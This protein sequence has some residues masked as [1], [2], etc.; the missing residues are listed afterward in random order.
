M[1]TLLRDFCFYCIGSIMRK[2]LTIFLLNVMALVA[3]QPVLAMHYCGGK[4]YSWNLFVNN[5]D[6][7]CCQTKEIENSD[8]SAETSE[9]HNY[10]L[11][12]SHDNCCDFETIQVSTDDY[13]NKTQE[14]NS[15]KLS[16]SIENVWFILNDLF[17]DK[18]SE[19][20]TTLLQNDFP[21][22]GLFL[23]DVSI[24]NYICVYR[25]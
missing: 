3:I 7:S 8:C 21:P 13:Q 23:Q 17:N 4:L 22:G 20:H 14:I 12:K 6:S 2:G 1:S 11:N 16:V 18:I 15:D 25:I 10:N 24:L 9:K 5:D 19:P